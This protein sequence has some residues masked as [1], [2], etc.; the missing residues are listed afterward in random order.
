MDG[1]GSDDVPFPVDEKKL[2]GS[3]RSQPSSYSKARMAKSGRGDAPFSSKEGQSYW[4]AVQK[5][6][7][8][9]R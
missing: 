7:Y 8:P 5:P 4:T 9:K 3:S 1:F 2:S 6:R